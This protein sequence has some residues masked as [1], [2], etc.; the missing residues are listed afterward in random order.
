MLGRCVSSGARRHGIDA[1]KVKPVPANWVIARLHVNASSSFYHAIISRLSSTDRASARET[2]DRTL[3]QVRQAGCA[4]LHAHLY[5]PSSGIA[6]IFPASNL[7]PKRAVQVLGYLPANRART[8]L[9][10][11]AHPFLGN[12]RSYSPPKVC[13]QDHVQG[14][15]APYVGGPAVKA[16]M[17][18][19]CV[20]VDP[21]FTLNTL[22]QLSASCRVEADSP[23]GGLFANKELVSFH[24]G[25]MRTNG[26]LEYANRCAAR[27]W[28]ELRVV[29]WQSPLLFPKPSVPS[30]RLSRSPGDHHD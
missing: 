29:D 16:V 30:S 20:Q 26:H 8:C 1:D 23:A 27:G 2:L 10:S 3:R 17:H 5:R 14:T 28:F 21:C 9:A 7:H 22:A 18:R 24:N 13:Y 15:R 25:A 19:V 11:A 4:Y 6:S 12:R